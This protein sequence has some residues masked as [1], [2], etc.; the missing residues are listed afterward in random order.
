M[1]ARTF[2]VGKAIRLSDT[3]YELDVH[4]V[5]IITIKVP[6]QL[7]EKLNALPSKSTFLRTVIQKIIAGE[8]D[9]RPVNLDGPRQVISVRVPLQVADELDEVTEEL[10]ERGVVKSRNELLLRAIANELRGE[11]KFP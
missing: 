6:K 9:L 4:G 7:N 3:E 1:A 10:I 11:P 5:Q 2:A 8:A